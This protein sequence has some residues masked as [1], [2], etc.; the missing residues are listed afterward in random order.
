MAEVE[1]AHAADQAKWE[2]M[3]ASLAKRTRAVALISGKLDEMPARPELMQVMYFSRTVL[4]CFRRML[5]DFSLPPRCISTQAIAKRGVERHCGVD[6][7]DLWSRGKTKN[8][9]LRNHAARRGVE[10]GACCIKQYE[11]RF[12]ELYE[13]ITAKLEE[14]RRYYDVFNTLQETKKLLQKEI[15]LLNSIES[16]FETAMSNYDG[17]SKFVF[18]VKV[19][20]SSPAC[21]PACPPPFVFPSHAR[22]AVCNGRPIGRSTSFPGIRPRG[23]HN[24]ERGASATATVLLLRGPRCWVTHWVSARRL[25]SVTAR[26]MMHS[27]PAQRGVSEGRRPL[28]RRRV[29]V[30]LFTPPALHFFNDAFSRFRVFANK[31]YTSM[32]RNTKALGPTR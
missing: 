6:A 21:L 17:K 27:E 8:K 2:A 25:H 7:G 15:S 3:R 10:L 9:R 19:S 20:S 29:S 23:A 5:R 11:K 26:A 1:A 30:C 16:Q 4:K 31:L 24:D 13:Q 32:P 22:R 28:A 12:V 18:S 14:T